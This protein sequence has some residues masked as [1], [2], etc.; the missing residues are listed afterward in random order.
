MIRLVKLT[1]CWMQLPTSVAMSSFSLR[2][3]ADDR[4]G[5]EKHWSMCLEQSVA[6]LQLMASIEVNERP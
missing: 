2:L 4:G 6:Y 5:G 1:P 3:Q